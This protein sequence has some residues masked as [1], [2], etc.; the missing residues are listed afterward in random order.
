MRIRTVSV[1]LAALAF[2]ALLQ[3]VYCVGLEHGRRDGGEHVN[4][5]LAVGFRLTD[6]QGFDVASYDVESGTHERI[7]DDWSDAGC[8]RRFGGNGDPEPR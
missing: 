6:P 8:A 2:V 3:L 7:E 1:V 4:E 5:L